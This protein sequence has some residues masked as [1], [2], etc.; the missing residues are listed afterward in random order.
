MAERL[1]FIGS[2]RGGRGTELAAPASPPLVMPKGHCVGEAPELP[3]EAEDKVE[4]YKKTKQAVLLLKKLKARNDIRKV[5]ASQRMRAGRGKMRNPRR[6]Q[7]RGPSLICNE[8]SG[9]IRAF[10]NIPGINGSKLN[11]L[12][13]AP[14]GHVGR[15][16]IRT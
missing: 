1:E 15:F 2:V 10:R 4:G 14:D 11:I 9:I 8:D 5:Y 6:V 16:C 3:L 7:C 12:K 13:L